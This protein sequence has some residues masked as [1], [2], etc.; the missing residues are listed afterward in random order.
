MYEEMYKI[1]N[2]ELE[3]CFNKDYISFEELAD[4]YLDKCCECDYKDEQIRDNEN[5]QY[6]TKEDHYADEL[7]EMKMLGEIE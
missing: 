4:A 3:N 2:T 1:K 7:H 5:K 6:E